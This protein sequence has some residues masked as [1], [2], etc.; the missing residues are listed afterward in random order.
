MYI[1]S[2]P[3]A[4][5]RHLA[6]GNLAGRPKDSQAN[7]RQSSHVASREDRSAPLSFKDELL[8]RKD[9][10]VIERSFP[11]ARPKPFWTSGSWV[12]TGSFLQRWCRGGLVVARLL[13]G[14]IHPSRFR[15]V[16][17]LAARRQ[18]FRDAKG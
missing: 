13:S 3:N 4:I 12:W 2:I 14:L 6:A 17:R 10:F 16:W 8:V 1:E 7:D 11:L 9:A 15:N 18:R 5:P